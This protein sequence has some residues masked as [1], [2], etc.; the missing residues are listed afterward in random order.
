[1]AMD[2]PFPTDV[3][4]FD[5]DDRISF[6]KLD[7]KFI[8]VRGD[9]TEFEFDA[10]RRAWQPSDEQAP[11]ETASNQD[12]PQEPQGAGAGKRR[13]DDGDNGSEV[14]RREGVVLDCNIYRNHYTGAQDTDHG[15]SA[16]RR[17][18]AK[19]PE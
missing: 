18:E 16:T 14:S 8:A 4:E 5:G 17:E 13:H 19:A 3:Q 15:N 7:G 2:A 6:S 11:D 10:D 1:M 12:I 9:G